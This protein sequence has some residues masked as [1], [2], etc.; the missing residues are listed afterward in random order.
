LQLRP[1]ADAILYVATPTEL[2]H[3]PLSK[4]YDYA[5]IRELAALQN[6]IAHIT[7]WLEKAFC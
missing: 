4:G 1:V 6:C 3:L 7:A 5:D 2:Q